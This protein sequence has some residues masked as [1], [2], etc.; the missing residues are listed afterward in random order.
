MVGTVDLGGAPEEAV[1]DGNGHIYV[2]HPRQGQRRRC[3]H[4]K[5]KVTAHFTASLTRPDAGGM[6]LDVKNHVLFAAM[7]QPPADGNPQRRHGTIIA[8]L[9]IGTGVDGAVFNPATMEAFSS[10]GDGTMT[11]IKENSPDQ[12]RGRTDCPN[13]D[14]RQD[15]DLRC[16]DQS[17]HLTS[18]PNTARRRRRRPPAA[19]P[20]AGRSLI[21]SPSL[22]SE[23]SNSERRI[24]TAG[25]GEHLRH[26]SPPLPSAFP[27]FRGHGHCCTPANELSLAG[28]SRRRSW[29]RER[30]AVHP[31][32][33]L[34]VLGLGMGANSAIF[35]FVDRCAAS[36]AR[37]PACLG[38]ARRIAT[39]HRDGA[40]SIHVAAQLL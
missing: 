25:H 15:P 22:S 26:G 29:L 30:A 16:E 2:D 6:A 20:D 11:M 37:L 18:P 39:Q 32:S 5:P 21:R 28:H 7:P 14:Q 12:L 36:A 13:D 34:A 33:T 8:S 24:P 35:S 3:R 10:H 27:G 9:P 4:E 38:A 19:A 31:G 40:A 23:T 1:S 17:H